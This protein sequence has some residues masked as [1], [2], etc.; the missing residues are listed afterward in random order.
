MLG[1]LPVRETAS[2]LLTFANEAFPEETVE[3]GEGGS[4]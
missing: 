3:L 2:R 1:L 4:S